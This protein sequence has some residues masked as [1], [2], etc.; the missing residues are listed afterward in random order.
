[1]LKL[2]KNFLRLKTNFK[3]VICNFKDTIY[4]MYFLNKVV[5]Y[6]TGP[7][8]KVI[9][10]E[11]DEFSITADIYKCVSGSKEKERILK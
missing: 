11:I 4:N 2:L 6:V 8:E 9:P 3:K 1:L 5:S 10:D 7:S